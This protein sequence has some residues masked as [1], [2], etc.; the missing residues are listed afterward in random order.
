MSLPRTIVHPAIRMVESA[1][2]KILMKI[3][4]FSHTSVRFLEKGSV[5]S[6]MLSITLHAHMRCKIVQKLLLT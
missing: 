3:S 4:Q 5:I 1:P 2:L 6:R